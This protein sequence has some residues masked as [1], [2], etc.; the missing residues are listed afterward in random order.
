M[1]PEFEVANPDTAIVVSKFQ[2]VHPNPTEIFSGILSGQVTDYKTALAQYTEA[3]TEM[4]D[5]ALADANAEGHSFTAADFACP[6]WVPTRNFT[7]EDYAA[8]KK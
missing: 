5:K 1:I 8:L 2:E 6:E 7:A 4:W 3:A